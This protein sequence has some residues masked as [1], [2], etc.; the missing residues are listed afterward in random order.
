MRAAM[1][2]DAAFY[3]AQSEG[4]L[5]SARRVAPIVWERA[6]RPKSIIDVGC[7][8]GTWLTAFRELGAERVTG[9][10]GAYLD[11]SQLLIDPGE[12]R[13][14]DLNSPLEVGE[15]FDLAISLE[16]A[17]HLLPERS[18]SFVADLVRLAPIVLFSAAVPDQAGTDHINERWQDEWAEL[19]E[20]HGYRPLDVVRP[21]VWDDPEVQPWYAQNTLLYVSGGADS[22]A[23]NSWPLRMVHPRLFEDRLA[24][25]RDHLA[26]LRE[27]AT[28]FGSA[29]R[30]AVYHRVSRRH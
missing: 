23:E 17:E 9:L 4:S 2:Y 14:T 11:R 22:I 24:Q 8:V 20:H 27:T 18:E 5:L 28:E 30:R 10:D 3:A 29:I 26:T 13:P 1:T 12:F 19:F 21:A 6:M 15:T 25:E 16:V 7:G